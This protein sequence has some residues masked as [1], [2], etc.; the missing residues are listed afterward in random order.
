MYTHLDCIWSF[1]ANDFF[2]EGDKF[3]IYADNL[4]RVLTWEPMFLSLFS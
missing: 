3:Y 1:L 2:S 4:K